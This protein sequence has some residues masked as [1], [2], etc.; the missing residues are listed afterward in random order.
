M[1]TSDD[2]I[3]A[4]R[5]WCAIHLSRLC[6]GPCK[7]WLAKNCFGMDN[8]NLD[9]LHN[10]CRKCRRNIRIASQLRHKNGHGVRGKS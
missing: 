2:G 5:E 7:L 9:G 4:L 10:V 6:A 1:I 8:S 3:P